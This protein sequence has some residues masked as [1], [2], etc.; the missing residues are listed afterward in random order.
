MK[1]GACAT[2]SST[3]LHDRLGNVLWLGKGP[4]DK[5]ARSAGGNRG[6]GGGGDE[7]VMIKLYI[8][9]VTQLHDLRVCFK[10]NGKDHQ[11]K[12]LFPYFTVFSRITEP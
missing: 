5:D 11:V 4:A 10:A 6:K 12:L 3:C 2:G 8:K 7:I 9:T 1:E